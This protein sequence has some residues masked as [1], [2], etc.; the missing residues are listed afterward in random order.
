MR[1]IPERIVLGVRALT[2]LVHGAVLRTTGREVH[3]HPPGPSE[4]T[5]PIPVHVPAGKARTTETC[6]V[7]VK[8]PERA[9]AVRRALAM[10]TARTGRGMF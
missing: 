7:I 5:V 6:A 3:P 4:I 10:I 1:I 9:T 2:V 8:I